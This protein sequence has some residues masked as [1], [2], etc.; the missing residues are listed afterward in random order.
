MTVK[1]FVQIFIKPTVFA[2]DMINGEHIAFFVAQSHILGRVGIADAHFKTAVI[3]RLTAQHPD[4]DIFVGGFEQT[5][6]TAF[7]G[8]GADR[9]NRFGS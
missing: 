7:G 2:A 8:N 4:K 6:T 9:G 3:E 1:P 5:A